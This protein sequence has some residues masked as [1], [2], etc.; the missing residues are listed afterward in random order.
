MLSDYTK[1]R[2]GINRVCPPIT[3]TPPADWPGIEG[4]VHPPHSAHLPSL[5]T[6]RPND[7]R[8]RRTVPCVWVVGDGVWKPFCVVADCGVGVVWTW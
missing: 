3:E 4:L 8:P 2:Y 1:T 7:D 6:R 5:A